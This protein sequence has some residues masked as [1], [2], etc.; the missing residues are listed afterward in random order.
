METKYYIDSNGIYKGGF[1]GNHGKDISA[2]TEIAAP[3]P[4]H[5]SQVWNG[6]EWSEYIE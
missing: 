1:A 2:Y 6:T 5:A 4:D 3:P